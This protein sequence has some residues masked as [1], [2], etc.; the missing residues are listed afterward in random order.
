MAT[1]NQSVDPVE[2]VK[3]R[4]EI[5]EYVGRTVA[6]QRSGRNFKGLCPFHNEK[7]PSFYVFPDKGTWRCFGQCGEGGD[8]FS[9][10]LKR[11]S[12][13]FRTALQELAREAGVTLSTDSGKRRGR[14]DHLNSVISAA[15]DFF[16]QRFRDDAASEAREYVLR[17]RGI[18]EEAV[19]AFH[20][21][22]APNDW[23]ALRDYLS[24]R[25]Y[26]ERD[27]IA[28]GVLIER[29]GGGAYDR[30]RGRV[31]IPIADERGVFVGIG[32]R[33]MGS[34]QPKYLN[35]PQTEVFDKGRTLFGLHTA[36][37][38]IRKTGVAV[39]VEGY[40]DVIGP[41][42]AGF[43]NVVATM[44]TSLTEHHVQLLR[45]STRRIVL[46]LDPDAA[47]LQAAERAGGLLLGF[48][49]PEAA[50]QAAHSARAVTGDTDVDLRV[51]PLPAGKDPDE[52]ARA[53]PALWRKAIAEA[54]P[55][56]AFLVERLLAGQEIASSP[57]DARRAIDRVRPVLLA[58]TDPVERA[59]YVQRIARH[60]GSTEQAVD[61]RLRAGAGSRR[62]GTNAVPV[63]RPA[64]SQETYLLASLV[65]NPELRE[66]FGR[67]IP[68][69]FFSTEVDRMVFERWYTGRPA[70]DSDDPVEMR[71]AYLAGLRLPPFT[72]EQAATDVRAKIERI[73][74]E[75]DVVHLAAM[76]ERM[77]EV[78][79]ESGPEAVAA[80]ANKA[81][82]GLA[83]ATD[84]R[85]VAEVVFEVQQLAQ[86]MHRHE[87]I[88]QQGQSRS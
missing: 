54:P 67:L 82:R 60:L 21:G 55:F 32:G 40:M 39:V 29:E 72:A 11:D 57:A 3:R 79:R 78:E 49:S 25:G 35:S 20:I 76:S 70:G 68:A 75:R 73:K 86:S 24:T 77:A 2:E 30:F 28:A 74:R 26:D 13:D 41:W 48:D 6:L 7:T 88:P 38:E 80:I 33:A 34:D 45:R 84:E 1:Y 5:A 4:L 43:R 8:L 87:H 65:R 53:D 50:G 37:D 71:R 58:I 19:A 52:V 62:T 12:V 66:E 27:G 51:A 23:R 16:E 42:Q 56:A 36:A 83:T 22:W 47:G 63:P 46:A 64:A 31:T 15:V 14:A 61:E 9:F 85:D 69:G 59:V 44:G 10:V 17:T 81:W 18:G